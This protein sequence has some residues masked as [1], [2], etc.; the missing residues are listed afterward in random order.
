L[1]TNILGLF[2][3]RVAGA[4]CSI[5][6]RIAFELKQRMQEDLPELRF[7]DLSLLETR[8]RLQK[9]DRVLLTIS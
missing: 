1:S 7:A 2:E 3:E 6:K 8:D 5:L 4:Y 9:R